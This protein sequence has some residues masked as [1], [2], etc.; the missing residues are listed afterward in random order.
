M[1]SCL[2][3]QTERRNLTCADYLPH[4]AGPARRAAIGP[5]FAAEGARPGVTAGTGAV[6]SV[7]L[8]AARPGRRVAGGRGRP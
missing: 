4:R 6:R 8:E 5:G 2:H 3:S 1:C 7:F